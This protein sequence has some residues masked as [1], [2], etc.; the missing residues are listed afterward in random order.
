MPVISFTIVNESHQPL[1]VSVVTT[2]VPTVVIR[3]LPG[4][5]SPVFSH[6]GTYEVNAV[7]GPAVRAF[8][9]VFEEGKLSIN[10]FN[11]RVQ[12]RIDARYA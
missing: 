4:A 7:P 12:A 1:D 9:V 5:T 8:D 6:Q 10:P 3:V 11:F 2:D